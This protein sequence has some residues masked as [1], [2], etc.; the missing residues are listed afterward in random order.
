M[1]TQYLLLAF[2][3]VLCLFT[4]TALSDVPHLINFQGTLTDSTGNPIT[5]SRSMLFQLYNDSIA[6]SYPLWSETH[7]S[8]DIQDGLFQQILGSLSPLQDNIFNGT[9]KWL[10]I[11]VN[12]EILTPRTKIISVPYAFKDDQWKTSFGNTIFDKDGSVGIGETYPNAKLQVETTENIAIYGESSD[13]MG[14]YGFAHENDDY[15][16]KGVHISGRHGGLGGQYYG[17]YGSNT[18]GDNYGYIGTD[19]EAVYGYSQYGLAGNF[20]GDVYVS[21]DLTAGYDKTFLG[22]KVGLNYAFNDT[23]YPPTDGMIVEGNVGIGTHNPETKLHVEG[24]RTVDQTIQA[25]DAGGLH[26]ATDDGT[27]VMK[28]NDNGSVTI[29]SGGS[30][31]GE[32]R[33][34]SGTTSS[35]G[36]TSIPY[37]SGYNANNTEILTARVSNTTNAWV[38]MGW[39][40]GVSYFNCNT[41]STAIT[42]NHYHISGYFSNKPYRIWLMKMM[43]VTSED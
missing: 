40:D 18:G 6:I 36:I 1:K 31:I 20:I 22:S 21:S 29:G 25:D 16:V 12:G 41:T 5:G 7:P 10:Q 37:P 43:F 17:V 42:L 27:T 9:S 24:T 39:T 2:T 38:I 4:S 35:I 13:S 30:M 11:E 34:I 32:I 14:V 28:V 8:V 15:G 3:A 23:I 19:D 26:F 33:E